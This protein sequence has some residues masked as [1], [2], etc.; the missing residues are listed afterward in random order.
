MAE[1]SRA[2]RAIAILSPPIAGLI[3]LSAGALTPGYDPVSRTVSRLAVPGMPAAS[4]VDLAILL[5]ALSCFALVAVLRPP[6]RSCRIALSVSG[7][8]LV[9]TA[10]VH[11]DPASPDPSALHRAA[12]GVAELGLTAAALLAPGRY[13]RFSLAVGLA[14]AG[15]LLSAPILNATSFQA[16]GAWQRGLFG[17]A[18][19]WMVLIAVATPSTDETTRASAATLSSSGS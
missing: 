2:Y 11:L 9:V 19:S 5:V 10:M 13:R 7:L 12:S 4:A 6:A 14:E 3:I 18:L 8:A 1:V 17:L 16:W 15:I